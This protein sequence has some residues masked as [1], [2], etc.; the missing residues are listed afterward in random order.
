[1]YNY[2]FALFEEKDEQEK[3]EDLDPNKEEWK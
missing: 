3:K 2:I 1:V